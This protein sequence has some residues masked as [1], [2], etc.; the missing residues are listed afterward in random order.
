MWFIAWVADY[1]DP[2]DWLTLQFDKGVPNNSTNYGQNHS[3]QALNQQNNQVAME[4]AD[5]NTDE[6]SRMQSYNR[7]EQQLV[8]DVSW[9]PTTQT[10]TAVVLKSYV[11]GLTFN[12]QLEIPPSDWANIYIAQ[13]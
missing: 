1:P 11:K 6:A 3:L 7:I 2:Q 8:N 12:A 13:H 5:S 10:N 9:L 4:R